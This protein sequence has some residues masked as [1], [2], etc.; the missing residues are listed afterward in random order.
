MSGVYVGVLDQSD[1]LRSLLVDSLDR[2]YG[3]TPKRPVFDVYRLGG[4]SVI[5]RYVERATAASLVAKFY[6]NKWI[7]GS[8]TGNRE[9][10]V[11]LM[12]REYANA[13]RLR[14]LGLCCCPH[15]VVRPLDVSEACNCAL[16]EEYV[17]GV[18]LDAFISAAVTKGRTSELHRRLGDMA[19]YLA[20]LHNRSQTEA[21]VDPACAL[22]LLAREEAALARWQLLT[23]GQRELIAGRREGWRT[24]GWLATGHQVLL[25]GDANPTNFIF[26][27]CGGVTAIDVESSAYGDRAVDVGCIVAELKHL[28]Y[29]YSHNSWASEPY[30]RHFYADYTA[31]Q[32]GAGEHFA[33]LTTRGRFFMACFMLRI[34]QDAWLNLDYRRSLLQHAIECL[35]V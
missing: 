14:D 9:L 27:A 15:S 4:G 32:T 25:H 22:A 35:H 5:Y 21:P 3:A 19:A 33:E 2:H 10:R 30:I 12:H 8:Q 17:P 28:F 23:P 26:D 24:S 7:E 20:D 18:N 34:C 31:N 13:M 16:I 11:A 29:L 6:G 1:P